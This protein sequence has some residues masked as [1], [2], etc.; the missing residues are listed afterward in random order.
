MAAL[1]HFFTHHAQNMLHRCTDGFELIFNSLS[2]R[3]SNLFCGPNLQEI[4]FL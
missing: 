4:M 3:G 2:V 1:I